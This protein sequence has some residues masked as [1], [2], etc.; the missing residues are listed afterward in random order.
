MSGSVW[1][2]SVTDLKHLLFTLLSDPRNP[3]SQ[4]PASPGPGCSAEPE[5][6]GPSR[7]SK[8]AS[9]CG[10][11]AHRPPCA[12][13]SRASH[14]FAAS[15]PS[16][17]AIRASLPTATA[18]S[19][20]PQLRTVYRTRTNPRR[21]TRTTGRVPPPR[22]RPST[23]T[24]ALRAPFDL[25]FLSLLS[26]NSLVAHTTQGGSPDTRDMIGGGGAAGGDSR[27]P[28]TYQPHGAG[29]SPSACCCSRRRGRGPNFLRLPQLSFHKQLGPRLT[30]TPTMTT[31]LADIMADQICYSAKYY[32]DDHEY[33]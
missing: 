2:L 3:P 10:S 16:N 18:R 5:G 26:T 8:G 29:R 22:S 25:R 19:P 14:P 4:T 28:P 24:T 27:V 13:G 7:S 1:Q 12:Q 30:R 15:P 21:T 11:E 17:I 6:E 23:A 32:D 33:R 9:W 31:C 20:D